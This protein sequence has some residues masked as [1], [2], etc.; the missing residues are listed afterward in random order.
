MSARAT[1]ARR[2]TLLA[3]AVLL[4]AGCD[5]LRVP[6]SPLPIGASLLI[7]P[8]SDTLFVGDTVQTGDSVRFV[9]FV[10][11][12]AGDTVEF[13]GATWHSSDTLVATVDASGLVRARGVGEAIITA[14]AGERVSARIVVTHATAA[15][16]LLPNFDTLLLGD[17]VQLFAQAYD[18]AGEPVGGVRYDFSTSAADVATVDSVGLV[19]AIGVGEAR[20]TVTAAGRQ[21]FSDIAVIDTVPPQPPPP[22][23]IP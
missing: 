7:A 14:E 20:I 23:V 18:Q 6:T 2:L 17:S 22:I 21:A 4:A 5:E 16:L 8:Q 13:S 3:A 1:A 9:A 19:R 11:T 15:L 12:Y 10:R